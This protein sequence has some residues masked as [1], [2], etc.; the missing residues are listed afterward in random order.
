MEGIDKGN[1]IRIATITNSL[2]DTPQ[3]KSHYAS[4]C[5]CHLCKRVI[6]QNYFNTLFYFFPLKW[7]YM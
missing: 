5:L 1:S 7:L 6:L 4:F 3:I 2:Y